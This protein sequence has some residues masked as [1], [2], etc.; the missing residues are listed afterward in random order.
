MVPL[1]TDDDIRNL[2]YKYLIKYNKS[3]Q[4]ISDELNIEPKTLMFF[5]QNVYKNPSH[6]STER[7]ILTLLINEFYGKT[8]KIL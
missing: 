5:R 1:L 6:V 7:K 3:W 8:K 4:E 2:L